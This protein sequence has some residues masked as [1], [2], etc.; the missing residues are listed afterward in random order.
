MAFDNYFDKKTTKLSKK[1]QNPI[2]TRR[3]SEVR[4][5]QCRNKG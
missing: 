2:V 3:M 5:P 1:Q 4:M